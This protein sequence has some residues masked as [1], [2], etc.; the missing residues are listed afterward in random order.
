MTN[1]A[2]VVG[3]LD[4]TGDFDPSLLFVMGGAFGV[5]AVLYRIVR[6][7]ASPLWARAFSVPQPGDVDVRLVLD[8]AIFGVGWGL[9]GYCPGPA[10][11]GFASLNPD[12]VVFVAAMVLGMTIFA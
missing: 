4:V 8:A 1:P 6:R 12:T 10:L 9:T 7:R 5:H 2:Y 11:T 3:F